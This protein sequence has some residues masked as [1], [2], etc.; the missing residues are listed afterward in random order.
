M[1][2]FVLGF[3]LFLLNC[4]IIVHRR[5]IETLKQAADIYYTHIVYAIINHS[6]VNDSLNLFLWFR[7]HWCA[8]QV[9]T[10]SFQLKYYWV[11]LDTMWPF[12]THLTTT[13]FRRVW[14]IMFSKLANYIIHHASSCH[15]LL[16]NL[17]YNFRFRSVVWMM[18]FDEWTWKL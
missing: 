18:M 8:C 7:W 1:H 12:S 5:K 4:R 16:L 13:T 2:N 9:L 6:H 15:Q 11:L 10:Q 14:G 17:V 3:C